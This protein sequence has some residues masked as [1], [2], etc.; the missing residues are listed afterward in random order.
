MTENEIVRIEDKSLDNAISA[1]K[2]T[3]KVFE[4]SKDSDYCTTLDK[5]TVALLEELKQYRAIGTIEE[6]KDLKE[7]SVEK[8]VNI[9]Q[10]IDTKCSCGYVFSKHH[11]DGYY[12][13]PYE[14]KT[15][16]CPRC[17][18]KLGWE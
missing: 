10:W 3:I 16:H 13:I 15:E 14:N 9:E 12:S 2:T 6:F 17:G 7:K 8:K 4:K 1:Y 18:Q 11:G 5:V